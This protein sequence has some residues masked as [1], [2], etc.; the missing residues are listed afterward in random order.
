MSTL[1]SLPQPAPS[2]L[3]TLSLFEYIQKFPLTELLATFVW[4][5]FFFQRQFILLVFVCIPLPSHLPIITVTTHGTLASCIPTAHIAPPPILLSTQAGL[6]VDVSC[7]SACHPSTYS[8]EHPLFSCGC[9]EYSSFSATSSPII[10]NKIYG[11]IYIMIS[12]CLKEYLN[13]WTTK[14]FFSKYLL[15]TIHFLILFL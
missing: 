2:L 5:T 9:D 8:N 10:I 13:K 1:Q 14:T 3:N 15:I 4:A 11:K 6:I 12:I 7:Y